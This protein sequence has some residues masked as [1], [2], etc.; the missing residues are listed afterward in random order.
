MTSWKANWKG[1]QWEAN[2]LHCLLNSEIASSSPWFV[3]VSSALGT[4]NKYVSAAELQ[5]SALWE[6]V[7]SNILCP[8][9]D[10][11]LRLP[12]ECPFSLTTSAK[13]RTCYQSITTLNFKLHA[14]MNSPA[15]MAFNCKGFQPLRLT[16]GPS[17]Q[18]TCRFQLLS[19]SEEG[20][21]PSLPFSPPPA[22][23]LV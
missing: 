21:T 22:S 14:S 5:G 16:A 11:L 19:R 2:H 17:T 12:S 18:V 8:K 3:T 10:I 7:L 1:V 4:R 6:L 13:D 15:V 20:G 9:I 23:L